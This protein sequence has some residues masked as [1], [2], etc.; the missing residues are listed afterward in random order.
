MDDKPTA[1][2]AQ[3]SDEDF[4]DNE[5]EQQRKHPYTLTA[6]VKDII[7]GVRAKQSIMD[8]DL[9]EMMIKQTGL[10]VLKLLSREFSGFR[11]KM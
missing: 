5:E 9:E 4:L 6:K 3:D 10:L 2:E 11:N 7:S 1:G 8:D